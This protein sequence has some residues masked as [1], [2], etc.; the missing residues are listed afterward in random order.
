MVSHERGKN[1]HARQPY[2]CRGAQLPPGDYMIVLLLLLA[3]LAPPDVHLTASWLSPTRALIAWQSDAPSC[4]SVRHA[5]GQG[6]FIGR[7]EQGA[8]VTLG[9]PETDGSVRPT[10]G[11]VY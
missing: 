8:R 10:G 7:Y 5:T 3:L 4:L 9:G 1:R 11:D 6:V 2:L